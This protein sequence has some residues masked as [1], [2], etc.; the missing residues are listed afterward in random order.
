[1]K[2]CDRTTGLL[3]MLGGVV[4]ISPDSLLVRLA[5]PHAPVAT[6]LLWRQLATVIV[7]FTLCSIY[8]GGPTGVVKHACRSGVYF[9]VAVPFFAAGSLLLALAFTMTTVANALLLFKLQPLW[10]SSMPSSRQLD[11]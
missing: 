1:M 4:C 8:Y 3:L 10:A 7:Q 5:E 9:L 6:V 2:W 11:F